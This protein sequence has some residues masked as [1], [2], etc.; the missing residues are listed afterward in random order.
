MAKENYQ[1][2][3]YLSEK[4]YSLQ[5][6][7]N[8]L[9]ISKSSVFRLLKETHAVEKEETISDIEDQRETAQ[10]NVVNIQILMLE[11]LLKQSEACVKQPSSDNQKAQFLT[12][13]FHKIIVTVFDQVKLRT[14]Q[15]SDYEELVIQIEKLKTQLT[16]YAFTVLDADHK[17]LAAWIYLEKLQSKIVRMLSLNNNQILPFSK[18]ELKFSSLEVTEMERLKQLKSINELS[19]DDLG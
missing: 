11:F 15:V 7:A 2:A 6:I 13:S 4:G 12:N 1:N 16:Y 10:Q 5:Q 3:R 19:N 17:E 14:W 8:R 18:L 9:G